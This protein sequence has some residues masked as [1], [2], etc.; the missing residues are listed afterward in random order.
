M[1]LTDCAAFVGIDWADAE[2][3]V[4]LIDPTT[5]SSE[6]YTVK[7][8]PDAIAEWA[9][10]LER[11]FPAKKV[12]VCVEQ[13]KGALIYAL[14]KFDCFVL[15]PINPKQLASFRDALASSGAKDDPTDA[16]L[17]AELLSKHHERLRPWHPDDADTRKIRMLAE[18]RRNLVNERTA[19]TNR[20]KSRLK[21][22]FP[23]ALEVCGTYI[24]GNLA[25]ELLLRYPCLERLQAAD[26]KELESFYYE[27][28]CSRHKIV[29]DRLQK[30]RRATALT[31]DHAIVQSN[32]LLVEVLAKQILVLNDGIAQ[33]DDQLRAMM[34]DHPDA[35][36]FHS[37]PGAGDA[38]A[39]RLLAAMGSDRERVANAQEVQ[40]LSG[41]APVSRQSGKTRVVRQRWA[42]SRFLRQ[43][44]H[45]Y[46]AHSIQHSSWAKAYYNMMRARGAQ[47][48]AAVRALAFK[49]I[50]IIFRCWKDKTRY[51][52]MAY[53]ASLH[54]GQSPILKYL[55]PSEN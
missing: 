54:R 46:A 10:S 18:D 9:A 40:Q 48:H 22:Y 13:T 42:C 47:H 17:L 6:S 50:R 5:Q 33:Y 20:L 25:C 27:H 49:W 30:I 11:R 38:M 39:P 14:M 24:Y 45:E 7:Q 4:H 28:H 2:H 35:E 36:I 41:I 15:V 12:A 31:T 32:V 53:C 21:Q 34:K 23:L 29:A 1:S 55:T 37:F 3:A 8:D 26:D 43:T 19:L 51:D 16:H 44:F 52:E